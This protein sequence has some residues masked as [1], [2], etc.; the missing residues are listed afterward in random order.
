MT[1][2]LSQSL[3]PH[4]LEHSSSPLVK[5]KILAMAHYN[6]FEG[7]LVRSRVVSN[8]FGNSSEVFGSPQMLTP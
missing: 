3:L 7:E 4:F 6:V 8:G 5:T 2:L 1:F